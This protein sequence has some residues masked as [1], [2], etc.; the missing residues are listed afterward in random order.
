MANQ[1]QK[2]GS[3]EPRDADHYGAPVAEKLHGLENFGAQPFKLSLF[4]LQHASPLFAAQNIASTWLQ[5]THYTAVAFSQ[6]LTEAGTLVAW[7]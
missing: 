4:L 2:V 5:Q 6:S 1:T 7:P 3:S